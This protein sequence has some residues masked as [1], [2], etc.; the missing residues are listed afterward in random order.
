MNDASSELPDDFF[1]FDGAADSAIS[2]ELM[3]AGSLGVPPR[4]GLLAHLTPEEF[5]SVARAARLVH[6]EA[7]T[8]II[9]QG[10]RAD[11][12]FVLIDGTARVERSDTILATLCAGAFFGESAL[13]AG[14]QRTASVIAASRC[15]VWSISYDVFHDVVSEHLLA[16]SDAA[17]EIRRRINAQS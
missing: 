3:S 2:S 11:R 16:D 5:S 9:R 4:L 6:V 12:F 15:S 8:V 10:E 7:E 14:G 1:Q 13:L 17:A